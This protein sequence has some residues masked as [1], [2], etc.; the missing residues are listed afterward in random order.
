MWSMLK[1][2]K[3]RCMLPKKGCIP[4]KASKKIPKSRC[5]DLETRDRCSVTRR[6][7]TFLLITKMARDFKSKI[8]AIEC[9]FSKISRGNVGNNQKGICNCIYMQINV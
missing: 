3:R 5:A 4:L 7:H 1:G 8:M 2:N 9:V 6:D